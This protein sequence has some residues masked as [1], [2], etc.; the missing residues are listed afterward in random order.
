MGGLFSNNETEVNLKVYSDLFL[1]LQHN[2]LQL[3]LLFHYEVHEPYISYESLANQL[4]TSTIF[5][6]ILC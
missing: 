5:K 6:Q 3:K 4:Y 1:T 2:F